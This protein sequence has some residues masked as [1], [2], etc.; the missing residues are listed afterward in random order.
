MIVTDYDRRKAA[1]W[2]RAQRLRKAQLEVRLA[3]LRQQEAAIRAANYRQRMAVQRTMARSKSHRPENWFFREQMAREAKVIE[4]RRE[5][6]RSAEVS[7]SLPAKCPDVGPCP[8][9]EPRRSPA[10]GYR[11]MIVR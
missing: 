3:V 5:A 11:G 8:V 4:D 10:G 7:R 9:C 2:A 1:E 6:R